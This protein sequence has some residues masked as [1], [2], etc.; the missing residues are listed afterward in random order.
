GWVIGAWL[1]RSWIAEPPRLPTGTSFTQRQP[2][3]RDGK[4][5]L[6]KSWAGQRDG[7]PVGYLKGAP[8]EIG[9][10]SS[11]LLKDQIHTLENEFLDMVRGYVPQEWKLSLIKNYVI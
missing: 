2:E 3:S 7:L 4:V 6:G 1:L 10:A 5:W 8:F 9:Y 11:V